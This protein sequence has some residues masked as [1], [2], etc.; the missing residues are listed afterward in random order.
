V[1]VSL[2]TAYASKAT[3]G[4]YYVQVNINDHSDT[5]RASIEAFTLKILD[6]GGIRP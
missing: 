6:R 1:D 4:R 2:P 3:V 5:A